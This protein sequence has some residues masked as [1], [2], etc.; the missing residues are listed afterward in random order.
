MSISFH[1]L[2]ELFLSFDHI[3]FFRICQIPD[4]KRVSNNF[5]SS[6]SFFFFFTKQCL[7]LVKFN[8]F[9]SGLS[10]LTDV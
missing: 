8:M 6:Y 1:F 3:L 5:L 7:M 4:T 10:F 2:L 9:S